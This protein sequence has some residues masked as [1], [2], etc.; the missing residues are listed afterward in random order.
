[1]LLI[2]IESGVEL[3]RKTVE[4]CTLGKNQKWFQLNGVTHPLLLW[5]HNITDDIMTVEV[6][7]AIG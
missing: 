7:P 2:V 6:G 1:M 5:T 4:L 3:H